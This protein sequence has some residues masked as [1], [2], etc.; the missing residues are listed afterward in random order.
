MIGM[1]VDFICN[2]GFILFAVYVIVWNIMR[3]IYWI[4]CFRVKTCY[5]RNCIFEISCDKLVETYTKEEK[6]AMLEMI[7][8]KRKELKEKEEQKEEEQRQNSI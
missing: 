1:V 6:E 5:N 8:R 3:F 2:V 7:E 4:K